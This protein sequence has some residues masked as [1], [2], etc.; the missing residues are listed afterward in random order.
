MVA[1]GFVIAWSRLLEP[2]VVLTLFGKSSYEY[3]LSS[4]RWSQNQTLFQTYAPLR[5]HAVETLRRIYIRRAIRFPPRSA[6]AGY[7]LINTYQYSSNPFQNGIHNKAMTRV[8]SLLRQAWKCLFLA[9]QPV[10]S[11]LI[12]CWPLKKRDLTIL[13]ISS[14]LGRK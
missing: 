8:T 2:P 5:W 9:T 10:L 4:N 13:A 1:E 3:N 11:S 7:R 6:Y 14:K 12:Q